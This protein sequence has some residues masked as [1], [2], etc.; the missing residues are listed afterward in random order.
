MT[1]ALYVDG[2]RCWT[3]TFT[4]TRLDET[5]L[6]AALADAGLRLDR[7]LTEDHAWLRA[8]PPG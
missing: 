7:Y 2:S 8:V 6:A 4:E 3:Q 5:A 1:E